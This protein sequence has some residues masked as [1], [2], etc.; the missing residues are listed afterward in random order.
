MFDYESGAPLDYYTGDEFRQ[1]LE[2]GEIQEFLPDELPNSSWYGDTD[3]K[4][5]TSMYLHTLGI[6][7]N[8]F[9]DRSSRRAGEGTYNYVIFD[10]EDVD[11]EEVVK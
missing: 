4:K 11:I 7:G 5:H 3:P 9:L 1:A 6:K 10:P 8:R 2:R